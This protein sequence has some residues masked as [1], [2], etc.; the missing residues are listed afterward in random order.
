MFLH[1]LVTVL[2]CGGEQ[3]QSAIDPDQYPY[4]FHEVAVPDAVPGRH[5]IQFVDLNRDGRDEVVV[6]DRES[7]EPNPA[8]IRLLTPDL[9]VIDQVNFAERLVDVRALDVNG[10]GNQE[11]LA[12]SVRNDSLFVCAVDNRGQKLF[13]FLLATGQP[14]IEGGGVMRWDP[15]VIEFFLFDADGDGTSDLVSILMTGYARMPRGVVIHSIPDGRLLNQHLVGAAIR[16]AYMGDFDGDGR[17]ELVAAT[18]A[19]D[20]GANAGG[21]NDS[22]S[23]VIVFDLPSLEIRWHRETG[24]TWSTIRLFPDRTA[25]G[26]PHHFL[27][28]TWTKSPRNQKT[29]LERFDPKTWRITYQTILNEPLMHP[30]L[31]DL[32]SDTR[33]EILMRRGAD[34]LWMFNDRFEVMQKTR[35]PASNMV[36]HI[37]PDVDGDGVDEILYPDEANTYLFGSDLNVKAVYPSGQISNHP[38]RRGPGNPPYILGVRQGRFAL[39]ELVPNRWYLFHRYKAGTGWLLGLMIITGIAVAGAAHWRRATTLEAL[40]RLALDTKNRGLLVVDYKERIRTANATL[41]A[42]FG[43]QAPQQIQR[44]PVRDV[45]ADAPEMVAM[46]REILASPPL[47]VERSLEMRDPALH[48]RVVADPMPSRF[49]KRTAWLIRFEER[50][51]DEDDLRTY[52]WALMAQRVAHDIKNPLT[53]LLLNMQ[54]LQMKYQKTTPEHAAEFDTY[55]DRMTDRIEHLRRMT[56][57]FMKF[58]DLEGP[59]RTPMDLNALLHECIQPV[60]ASLPDDIDIRMQT[61]ETL[62]GVRVDREQIQSMLDNLISNAVN[63]MQTGGRIMITTSMAHNLH[64]SSGEDSGPPARHSRD[65]VLLEVRD[66]GEGISRAIRPDIFKPG[67][68]TSEHG[69]GLGLALVKKIVT[70]HEGHIEVESEEGAGTVVSVYL[71]VG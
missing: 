56:H 67:V 53:A 13:Q 34:E 15:S 64:Y 8:H 38:Q 62:P 59:N 49:K 50:A 70:D 32:N 1:L 47:R 17:V 43:Y 33:P 58:V 2:A 65:Y 63:A 10:D 36:G 40:Q 44:L 51:K 5:G 4:R 57:N 23:Y 42:W 31:I 19:P 25:G 9:E 41:C 68:T 24:A 12:T 6:I 21:F 61:A 29:R 35:L 30:L 27:G 37:L 66:T 60:K 45:F 26:E 55:V 3:S 48:L 16:Q 20:N 71:P 7:S 54:Q 22:H 69:I 28:I 18:D 11:L 52:G 14:R 39:L 46:I